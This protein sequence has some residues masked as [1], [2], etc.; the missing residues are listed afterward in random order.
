M[1]TTTAR[2]ITCFPLN[3]DR[4]YAPRLTVSL[5]IGPFKKAACRRLRA[6]QRALLISRAR[7]YGNFAVYRLTVYNSRGGNSGLQVQG[8]ASP[9]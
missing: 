8:H 6:A 5:R 9:L 7:Y 2:F 1:A 3:P 4:S